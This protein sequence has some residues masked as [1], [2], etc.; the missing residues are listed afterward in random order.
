M[1]VRP[2]AA[3]TTFNTVL[4]IALSLTL[5][6]AIFT[7][8]AGE[9]QAQSAQLNEDTGAGLTLDHPTDLSEG[10]FVMFANHWNDDMGAFVQGPPPG[11]ETACFMVHETTSEGVR[12]ELT[13][14]RH[15]QW[16]SG[17]TVTEFDTIWF[18][19]TRFNDDFPNAVPL[20][21]LRI[22]FRNTANCG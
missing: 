14:G 9:A 4:R 3:A 18:S 13:S 7:G 21:E 5:S 20:E 11:S 17:E 12:M 6:A 22:I 16:W 19:S 15:Y 10:R 1:I 8:M 2:D